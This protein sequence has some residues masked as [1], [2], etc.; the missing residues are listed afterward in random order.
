MRLLHIRYYIFFTV[1]LTSHGAIWAQVNDASEKAALL[2]LYNSTDGINWVNDWNIT[3]LQD[4]TPL[5]DIPSAHLPGIT[6][7]NGDVTDIQFASNNN[8]VGSLPASL[9]NLINLQTLVIRGSKIASSNRNRISGILPVLNSLLLLREVD[10]YF[11]DCTGEVGWLG[12]SGANLTTV[13]LHSDNTSPSNLRIHINS[14]L[15]NAS[16]LLRLDLSYNRVTSVSGTVNNDLGT[17]IGALDGLIDLSL[18]SCNLSTNSFPLEFGDMASLKSLNLSNNDFSDLPGMISNLLTLESL[19]LIDCSGGFFEM[20]F[21]PTF[22]Q[23]DQLSF[24]DLS[25]NQFTYNDVHSI[26]QDL[27]GCASLKTLILRDNNLTN[28]SENFDQLTALRVLDL[29]LN[30][31]GNSSL[32]N[33]SGSGITDLTLEACDLGNML[34]TGIYQLPSLVKLDIGNDNSNLAGDPRANR[35]NLNSIPVQAVLTNPNLNLKTLIIDW[36][37]IATPAILPAWFGSGNMATIEK[38]I[39]NN[40]GLSQLIPSPPAVHNFTSLVNLKELDLSNNSLG[41]GG[42]QPFPDFFTCDIFPF[43]TIFNVSGNQLP[44]PL[45]DIRSCDQL[46]V[47]NLSNN[48]FSEKLLIK[49]N[50]N[51]ELDFRGNLPAL[52]YLNISGNQL[53]NLLNLSARSDLNQMSIDVS[54]NKFD[55]GDLQ[56]FYSPTCVKRSG[57]FI[58]AIQS[59]GLLGD[60]MTFSVPEGMQVTLEFNVEGSNNLYRWEHFNGGAWI[61]KPTCAWPSLPQKG[62]TLQVSNASHADIGIY[63]TRITNTCFPDLVFTGNNVNLEFIPPLCQSDI[64]PGG[65]TFKLDKLTGSIIFVRDG[66]DIQI[67][68]TCV[69]GPSGT[70]DNVVS[71]SATVHSDNWSYTYL[72]ADEEETINK[73]E[74]GELGKWRQKATYA[75]NT[76]LD[77]SKDKNFNA[78]TY[79]YTIFNHQDIEKNSGAWIKVAEIDKFSPHGDAVEERNALSIPSTVKYGYNNT[80]PYLVAQNAEYA[81][82]FFESFENRYNTSFEDGFQENGGV[83]DESGVYHSGKN[84]FKITGN[85]AITLRT[86][87]V[88]SQMKL[89]GLVAKL[90]VKGS[91]NNTLNF[92]LVQ[93]NNPL[94]SVPFK[95]VASSGEWMLYQALLKPLDFESIPEHD[96]PQANGSFLLKIQY[97]GSAT[98]HLDDIRIQPYDAEMTA[99]VYDPLTLRVLAIFDDQ[100]FGLYYQYNAEGKLIR[101]KIETE[102]G[103]KTI[104]ETQYNIKKVNK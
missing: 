65:G 72:N 90:W 51:T 37:A 44:N 57:S 41:N 39:L 82:V 14:N 12:I 98:I 69:F 5:A 68:M 61:C 83:L 52:K 20:D 9:N 35:I 16:S 45:P 93:N 70:V 75:F 30:R 8:M 64:P 60:P 81:S 66:C 80:L 78:G 97:T 33:L 95:E 3:H 56:P 49:G 48:M 102:R 55:F 101:K 59:P 28:V 85:S 10:L 96:L 13:N 79:K 6:V 87:Y 71:A 53:S 7:S 58:Y 84:S 91:A 18:I 2:E 88:N 104:Q 17:S 4:A 29:S 100:H 21:P 26:V 46:Q 73:Y 63:R 67:P 92:Q 86:F 50:P 24:L 22:G 25:D 42:Q 19:T 34:P 89:Q 74:T 31:L 76:N 11:N 40:N 15:A 1:L 94:S 36:N 103:I 43:L 47:L 62:N 99:Y 32:G 27:I 38:L 54:I 23:L 77:Q